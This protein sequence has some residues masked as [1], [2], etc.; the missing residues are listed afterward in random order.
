MTR[1]AL[2]TVALIAL[3][4]AG[5][6]TALATPG[7]VLGHSSAA[8]SPMG[9]VRVQLKVNKFVKKGHRL[10]ATGMAVATYTPKTGAP[11]VVRHRFTAR[12]IFG[13]RRSRSGGRSVSAVQQQTTCPV[14]T[15]E[16]DQLALDLLGLHV[17]LSKVVLTITADSSGGVLGKLFCSLAGKNLATTST[18]RG[19]S[20]S[21]HRSG[22]ATRGVGFGV[23][24]Q[25]RQALTPG[26]CSIVDLL[27]GPLHLDLLGLIVDLNQIHLQ[28]TADP[29]GGILR[30]LLC[31]VSSTTTT[32]TA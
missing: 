30:S 18:A 7:T 5:A 29:N 22:L 14:L 17:D 20:A 12:V 21:A 16:L 3:L 32:A 11:T 1:L 9:K 15:L 6:V 24:T 4:A 19:L 31:S 23:P 13:S 28:I 2:A 8:G 26:P 27:L 10:V 25:Q